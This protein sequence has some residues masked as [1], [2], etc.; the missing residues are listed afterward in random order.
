MYLS[1]TQ[2]NLAHHPR[3][4]AGAAEDTEEKAAGAHAAVADDDLGL[5]ILCDGTQGRE[6]T[7]P[8]QDSADSNDGPEPVE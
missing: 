8:T 5:F 1:Y 7:L 2:L 3:H 4:K 6:P